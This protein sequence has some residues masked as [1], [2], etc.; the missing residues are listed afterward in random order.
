MA[1]TVALVGRSRELRVVDDALARAQDGTSSLLLVAGEPGI[2]KSRLL[3]EAASRAEAEGARVAWGRTWELGAA[4]A[5]WPWIE[6]LRALPGDAA[7]SAAEVLAGSAA[8]DPAA[9]FAVFDGVAAVLRELAAE[10]PLVLLLDDLHAA[11]ASSLQLL[12]LVGRRRVPGLVIVGTFRDRAV[13]T[14]PDVDA[15]LS[16]VVRAAELVALAALEHVDVA[17]I[18]RELGIA[19]DAAVARVY[20]ASDGNP[21]FVVELFSAGGAP[22]VVPRGVRAALGDRLGRLAP[23]V[24]R[25][26]GA[27]AVLGRETDLLLLAEVLGAAPEVVARD[28]DEAVQVGVMSERGADRYR[29]SHALVAETVVGDLGASERAELH[30]RAAEVM[31]E[32]HRDD[33]AA[34]HAVIAHHLL[35]AGH[36]AA[37]L[38]VDAAERAAQAAMAQLAFEDAVSLVERALGALQLAAPGDAARRA[39]LLCHLAEALQRAGAHERAHDVCEQIAAL[40]RAAGDAALLAEAAWLRGLEL[41]LGVVD[42]GMT[43]LL[44]EALDAQPPGDSPTRALLGARLASALQPAADPRP[45]VQ[46]ARD[47]IAMARRIADRATQL[48]VLDTAMG[49]LIDYVEAEERIAINEEILRLATEPI[50]GWRALRARAR[51]CFDHLELGDRLALDDAVEAFRAHSARLQA[52]RQPWMERMFEALVASMEGRFADDERLVGEAEAAAAGNANAVRSIA[53]HR[54]VTSRWRADPDSALDAGMKLLGGLGGIQLVSLMLWRATLHGDRDAART[55]LARVPDD[56]LVSACHE[57]L[58]AVFLAEGVALAGGVH[59]ARLVYDVLAPWSGRVAV[60]SVLGFAAVD[61]IDAA[62]MRLAACLGDDAAVDR[63]A[64]AAVELGTRLGAWP[65]LARARLGYADA[66][67]ARGEGARAAAE[68]AAA[69]AVMARFDASAL[70]APAA[71]ETAPD[72]VALVQEGD[73]WRVSGFGE[74]AYLKD[75]RGL[76]MLARLV[77]EPGREL[78][79]LDLSGAAATDGGD[80]GEVLDERARDAYR[81]RLAELRAEL[82]EAESFGDSG[83][84][85]RARLEADALTSELA[86]ALGLGGRARRTGSAAERARTNVQRRISSAIRSIAEVCPGLGAHLARAVRTGTFCAYAP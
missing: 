47:A 65:S 70:Q 2:G 22:G 75:S 28:L 55:T 58:F 61:L 59:H 82:D 86:R 85:E 19:D 66:L 21:L 38:A 53:V 7:R 34:P 74:S 78:H 56:E 46:A 76:H 48:R 79:A 24:R 9:R 16:R 27:A 41:T 54:M 80:A 67:E 73:L 33:P 1:R 10:R 51:L 36:L 69:Q 25:A 29:F 18:A 81:A 40:A 32:R 6:V 37:G 84:A 3:D 68:R 17:R 60:A 11:D 26:L 49:A 43:A 15:A 44:R 23:A 45:P 12:E 5:F 64:R 63:H 77:G 31:S 83:R 39:T 71:P 20:E 4:P 50:D 13:G 42:I 30:L 57:P 35:E 8:A 52:S 14:A 62:L 72:T